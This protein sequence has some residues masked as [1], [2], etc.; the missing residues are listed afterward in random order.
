ME[1][2]KLSKDELVSK[3]EKLEQDL[4]NY[5][6]IQNRLLKAE[7]ELD[8][9]QNLANNY[10]NIVNNMI[11][12]LNRK[13]E[14]TLLNKKGH[15]IL[16]YEEGEL[17]GKEW[18]STCLPKDFSIEIK[19]YFKELILGN[20]EG[21]ETYENSIIRKDGKERIVRW[22]NTLVKDDLGN[23]TG[24][25]SSGEDITERRQSE[26]ALKES[27][28]RLNLVLKSSNDSHWDWD[29]ANK[30][31]Y[32]SPQWWAQIG[33]MPNELPVNDQLWYELTHIEDR[34]QIDETLDK[35]L[36]T[37][38]ESYQIEFSLKH[39]DGHYTPVLSRGFI[40]RDNDGNMLRVTGTNMDL[41]ER[42]K[43]E[44]TLLNNQKRYKKAQSLGKVGNWE[45]S[46]ET[47]LFWGS[48]EAKR[49]FG[50]ELDNIDFTTDKI[51]SCIPER[52]R[53]HQALID[54]IEHDKK[55]DLVFD[56]ITFD[57]GIRKTIHSVAE[58]ERDAQ[59]NIE[60]ITGVISDITE[61]KQAEEVIKSAK[62]QAER[63]EKYYLSIL[64]DMGDAVFVK[65]EQSRF[66]LVNDAFCKMANLSEKDI[67]GRTLAEEVAPEEHELFL[68]IDKE[69]FRTGK[70]SIVEE[71]IT[72]RG[73]KTKTLSTRKTRFIDSKG[74]KFIVGAIRDISERKQAE[75][76]LITAKEKAEESDRLKS[77]F[78]ANMS[79]EIRTPMSG[80]IGFTSLL[81]EPGLSGEEQQQYIGI[82]EKSGA[83]MLNTIHD[84]IDI[85]KIESGQVDVSLSD[86][87]LNKQIDELFDFFL[88][89]AE[90][91]NIQLSFT[92]KLPDHQVKIKSDKEKLDSILTNLIKNAIKYTNSGGIEFGYTLN[93][94][95]DS[96]ELEFY[97]KDTGVGI[98]KKRQKAIFNRFEQAD[99]EDRQ[100][101]EGSGLGLAI[102]KAYIEMLGG[103][104]WLES[105]EGVGSQFY[106][107]IPYNSK[108]KEVQRK[109]KK[110][111][112]KQQSAKK[113]LK[114]LIVEDEEF[115]ITYLSIVLKEYAKEILVAKTG[116]EAVEMCN[117]NPDIDLILMDINIPIMNG[118]DATRKI[119]M[120][121]KDVFILAQTAY[122]Q[123][124]DKEKCIEAGCNNFIPKPIKKE[125]LLG[126]ITNHF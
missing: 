106:F 9:Q 33:Y 56:I 48:D 89:E 115:V 75:I 96:F 14:I 87:N 116:I 94:K 43:V 12:V 44:N 58:L 71:M 65:D 66:M 57:K 125:E 46:P 78:L 107:T 3:V 93:K 4:I 22:F 60:K 38:L 120:F 28:E 82:I 101:Y 2:E 26:Q 108:D 67:V 40:T 90:K 8:K 86:L 11:I 49:I 25:L 123:K 72:I 34:A 45:Y 124:E 35:A 81:K 84:I 91:K 17:Y 77:A 29:F 88:V 85:S 126:I 83:R 100:V 121:N 69:V 99:I 37:D 59:G 21:Q 102:S 112:N 118:Y 13:G 15:D 5:K 16:G 104:I 117:K 103:K 7:E 41:T 63:N 39:K 27:E 10:L 122:T 36:K 62:K 76:E 98:P 54:L 18:F 113:E 92:N 79:H 111:S 105:E 6:S 114:I 97:I 32:Y 70:E 110:S 95:T 80:I 53:V 20:V 68:K 23:I 50:F 74:K 64:N 52:E 24:L 51:E 1:N 61:R 119:R 19:E 55:Y 31:I 109:N 30:K 73:V 47:T 42:K